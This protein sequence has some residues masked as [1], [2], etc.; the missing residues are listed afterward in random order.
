MA[1]HAELPQCATDS[2]IG[3]G[4]KPDGMFKISFRRLCLRKLALFSLVAYSA[5]RLWREVVAGG[6]DGSKRRRD[7][8][9]KFHREPAL[10]PIPLAP[11]DLTEVRRVVDLPFDFP[12]KKNKFHTF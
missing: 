10:P 8:D 7:S 12:Q 9:E 6:G 1:P 11:P 2:S 5:A 4:R 3:G